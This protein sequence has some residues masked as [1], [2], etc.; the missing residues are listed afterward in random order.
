M[1]RNFF[2][3]SWLCFKLT[4]NTFLKTF[5]NNDGSVT[6]N[7]IICS[8]H[9]FVMSVALRNID[10]RS[11]YATRAEESSNVWSTLWCVNVLYSKPCFFFKLFKQAYRGPGTCRDKYTRA[12]HDYCVFSI[13]RT[14][15]V[16][17]YRCSEKIEVKSNFGCKF[18]NVKWR[19]RK[20]Q[21]L[22]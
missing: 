7:Y 6:V 22:K 12:V 11:D 8:R 14:R 9:I 5:F 4:V 1:R 20:C 15:T 13:Q 21:L 3:I 10:Y 16:S 17:W 2:D 19:K 18:A